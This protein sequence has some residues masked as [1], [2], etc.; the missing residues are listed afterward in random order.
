MSEFGH[1]R[2]HHPPAGHSDGSSNDPHHRNRII[3]GDYR[4]FFD[5]MVSGC[6]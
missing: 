4:P 2:H 5:S 3:D 6:H 1:C